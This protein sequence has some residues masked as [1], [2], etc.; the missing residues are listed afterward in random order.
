MGAGAAHEGHRR[1]QPRHGE[2]EPTGAA[3][4]GGAAAREPVQVGQGQ[5]EQDAQ[6][7]VHAR[8][9]PHWSAAA[10]AAAA[11]HAAQLDVGIL[12]VFWPR[13]R[14]VPGPVCVAAASGTGGSETSRLAELLTASEASVTRSRGRRRAGT[15]LGSVRAA[16][17]RSGSI[18]GRQELQ[19]FVLREFTMEPK[20]KKKS[21]F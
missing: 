1:L 16:D 18:R 14:V 17:G 15:V 13:F 21:S 6:E 8:P 19:S 20:R 3:G 11:A 4:G 12:A 9:P 5:E 2:L 7:A 10:A